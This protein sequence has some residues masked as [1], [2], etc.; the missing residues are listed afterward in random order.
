MRKSTRRLPGRFS[1][2]AIVLVLSS[3]VFVASASA[4]TSGVVYKARETLNGSRVVNA[5]AESAVV[6]GADFKAY[7]RTRQPNSTSC[8]SAKSV[9][10]GYMGVLFN[11]YRDGSFCGQ[12][13][14]TYSTSTA[15]DYGLGGAI[16]G[17]PSGL[18]NY[19]TNGYPRWYRGPS[20]PY[21]NGYVIHFQQSPTGS[22]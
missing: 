18:Q 21:N 16:C 19:Y 17:N 14:P 7:A 13:G 20:Y 9:P 1:Y 15:S 2:A 11:G 22:F 4:V 5:C 10:G 3:L 12:A 8:S 6:T